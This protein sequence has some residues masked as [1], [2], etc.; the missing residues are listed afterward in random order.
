MKCNTTAEYLRTLTPDEFINEVQA[1]T[2]APPSRALMQELLHRYADL[3]D[4][5][6]QRANAEDELLAAARAAGIGV[7]PTAFYSTKAEPPFV[8]ILE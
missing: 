1:A 8:L 2:Y 5:D 6:V 7:P 4:H 3:V